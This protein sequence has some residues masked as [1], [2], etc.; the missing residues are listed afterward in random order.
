MF[1][2][3]HTS[4]QS[5][6]LPAGVQTLNDWDAFIGEQIEANRKGD[7]RIRIED[8]EGR[9][10][11]G[12]E[13][14]LSQER[15]DFTLGV[16]P[17]GHVSVCNELACGT[18]KAA[19]QYWDLI[20][21]LF[22]STTLWWGWRVTEPKPGIY[23]FDEACEGTF[24]HRTEDPNT[25]KP[26]W[27]E[28]PRTY[29]PWENM[30]DRARGLGHSLVGHALLYPRGD[31]APKW[32]EK[33]TPEEAK[34][35]LEEVV[36]CTVSRYR[37]EVKV[38]HPVNENFPGIQK[39]G[40]LQIDEGEVYR[41]VREEAPDAELVNNGGYEIEPDFFEQAIKSAKREGVDID[42]LGIRGYHELYYADDLDGMKRRWNHFNDLVNRFGKWLR[43]TEIGAN[44]KVTKQGVHD[45]SLFL[46]GSAMHEGI[47][48]VKPR[49]GNLPVLSEES[50][51]E[52][53]VR[54]YKMVFA[55]PSMRECSY[56]DLLDD[57]TWNKVDGGLVT[58]ERKPKLAYHALNELFH[59]E[60]KTSF[61]GVTDGDGLVYLRGFHGYYSA[62]IEGKGTW[63]IQL[64]PGAGRQELVI[65]AAPKLVKM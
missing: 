54:M 26:N 7:Y 9:P 29:G 10:L 23:A 14:K 48:S 28:L 22:N 45:P 36:R 58:A 40:P 25:K 63:P 43:Y 21:N 46:S 56:W 1:F 42:T 6:T 31:V 65:S 19:D 18:G 44:S 12:K 64:C 17:N 55:H 24:V 15:L 13:V 60:W 50:Q 3:Y 16:C 41:W 30:L 5:R 35:H 2:E 38:W 57:Y 61:K 34:R 27:A 53:L 62:E 52:F 32:I 4:P 59:E 49:N 11:R 8:E 47:V 37:D 39:V 20:G 33:F 51:A